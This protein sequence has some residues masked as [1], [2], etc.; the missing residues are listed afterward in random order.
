MRKI[1]EAGRQSEKIHPVVC[2]GLIRNIALNQ[3]TEENQMKG[4]LIR[5]FI[6]TAAIVS[7]SYVIPGIEVRDVSSAFFAAAILGVLNAFVRPVLFLLTL[8][9][10]ILSFGLFLFVINALM[11]KMASG[12]I[13]GFH[14]YGLGSAILGSLVISVVNWFL[15]SF[16]SDRGRIE[17]RDYIRRDYI[18]LERKD[19]NRWE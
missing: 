2:K 7:A 17:R 11:L 12:M 13:P 15:S 19:G 8:P 10:T 4:I 9:L 18:D 16:V 14:V 5:W 6:L 3:R 1:A